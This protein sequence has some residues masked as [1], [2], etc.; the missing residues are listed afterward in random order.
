M[1]S[2]IGHNSITI[3]LRGGAALAFGVAAIVWPQP[4]LAVLIALLG[5]FFLLDAL[6]SSLAAIYFAEWR[7][8]S[9][10]LVIEA[11]VALGIGGITL[12]WPGMTAYALLYLLAAWAILVGII[13]LVASYQLRGYLQH[14]RMLALRG[15]LP[16]LLGMLLI[17]FPQ[18]GALALIRLLGLG[19]GLN[20][21]YLLALAYQ[22][23]RAHGRATAL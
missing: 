6:F 2:T 3:A 10:P 8:A 5:V 12:F 23:H 15:L 21:L 7:V 18:E 13:Q 14:G 4:T 17:L 11:V 19:L 9:W 20:G 16:L 1:Q 22:L